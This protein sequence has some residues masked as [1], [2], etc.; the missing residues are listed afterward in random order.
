MSD[1]LKLGYIGLGL[2]GK[3]MA[4]NLLKA[5]FE[6]VVHNRSQGA[7]EEVVAAG[8]RAAGSPREVAEQANVVFTNLPDSPDVEAIALGKDG[9]IEGAKE[10]LIFVDHSTIKPATARRIAEKL[11]EKGV[12]ALDAPVSGGDIG[13]IKGTLTIMVGGEEAALDKVRPALEAMGSS[14]THIGGAGAGQVAKCCNQIMVAAQMTGM[15]ELLIFARKA[16]VDPE[17]VV[18]AIQGGAAQCW[19]L[20]NKP[21][22]LFAGKREPG[23]KAFMQAKDLGIVMDT[24]REYGMPL[25]AASVNTQLYNAMLEMGMRDLDNSAVVGVFEMLAGMELVGD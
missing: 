7:V 21:A 19:A 20:D 1:K 14:I 23:F 11:A 25:P 24:A 10:G 18:A 3:P 4:Q 12:M 16:G 22:N 15:G 2:M 13:A 6:V 5:G 8:A 17:K 9:V